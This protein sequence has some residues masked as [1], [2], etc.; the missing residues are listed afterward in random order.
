MYESTNEKKSILEYQV[1]PLIQAGVIVLAVVVFI[2]LGRL[3]SLTGLLDIDKG[4]PWLVACSFTLFYALFN[5]VLS[6]SATDQNKYWSQSI[7]GYFIITVVGGLVAYLFSGATMD[8]VGG[9]RPIYI[10]FTMG[11]ILLLIIVRS[12]RKIVGL[13]ERE[14][15]R[16][17]GED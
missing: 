2:L 7:F 4:T 15:K 13:A 12:M 17:R 1:S 16:L 3:I 8:E 11:Y 10:V 6:L 14:D 5:S 9:Y